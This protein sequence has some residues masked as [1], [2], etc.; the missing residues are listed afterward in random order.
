MAYSA[1]PDPR[2]VRER[3]P[4]R[5]DQ[6]AS[7]VTDYN[8]TAVD[9]V[10][11]EKKLR[12]T[13]DR[14]SIFVGNTFPMNPAA[15]PRVLEKLFGQYGRVTQIVGRMNHAFVKFESEE[16]VRR[17]LTETKEFS[18][19]GMRLQVEK[20]TRRKSPSLCRFF[21]QNGKCAYGD[22]CR[23]LHCRPPSTPAAS[24]AACAAPPPRARSP[25]TQYAAQ[26]A[27]VVPEQT[28]APQAEKWQADVA[29]VALGNGVIRD[30]ELLARSLTNI[31]LRVDVIVVQH[32]NYLRGLYS[33][34]ERD[35]VLCACVGEMDGDLVLFKAKRLGT[36]FS[37]EYPNLTL[38][39]IVELVTSEL[40]GN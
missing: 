37:P 35:R 15:V 27:P 30:C 39:E 32:S 18:I 9:A 26:A 34:L 33:D 29:V 36:K 14:A 12:E 8:N 6:S 28:A 3:S 7:V 20:R 21:V 22:S 40:V 19:E 4:V 16:S 11:L 1:R 17:V 24:S 23:F 10:L 5:R 13:E 25:P 38:K 2:R 31:G